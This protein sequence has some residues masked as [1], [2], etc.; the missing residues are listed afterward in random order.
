[1]NEFTGERVIPGQVN[2]DLWAEHIARYAFASRFAAHRRVLDAG[3]G[4]GYGVETMAREATSVVGFDIAAEA[5]EF[6]RTHSSASNLQYLRASA[7]ALPFKSGSFDLLTA[8][9]VIEHLTDWRGLIQEAARVLNPTGLFLVSTPNRV[10]YAESRR[11]HGPNPYHVHEFGFEE[12]QSELGEYFP[13]VAIL[14]QNRIEAFAFHGGTQGAAQHPAAQIDASSDNPENAHFFI[15]LASAAPL[16]SVQPFL[17]VPRAANVLR[18]RE[19]H[20][21]LLETELAQ[22]KQWL[23]QSIAEHHAL[24]L[25]HEEQT[26]H[27]AAQN[28]WASMA[29]RN[30][31]H[32]QPLSTRLP[33]ISSRSCCSPRNRACVGTSMSMAMSRAR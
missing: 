32:L 17:Y 24:Q 3:C 26:E 18:E 10:Y 7:T 30:Y 20:I 21:Q 14:F 16:P 28:R 9:E 27:L 6:A 29:T 4:T 33:I 31:A 25:A 22:S 5:I 23:E 19:H 1:M 8:F 11:L 12:F 13:H 2:E 15:A